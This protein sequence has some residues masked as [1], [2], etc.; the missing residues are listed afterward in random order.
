MFEVT[1]DYKKV[2]HCKCQDATLPCA[3]CL[4]LWQDQVTIVKYK[5]VSQL[6]LEISQ[7]DLEVWCSETLADAPSIL[8]NLAGINV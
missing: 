4:E 1:N 3:S 5:F 6:V 8:W 7:V 2:G